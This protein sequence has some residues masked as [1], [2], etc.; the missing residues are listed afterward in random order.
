[1]L[2][3][4]LLN[5]QIHNEILWRAWDGNVYL[6]GCRM[7][8]HDAYPAEYSWIIELVAIKLDTD[9]ETAKHI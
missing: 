4:Y 1:M 2:R 6:A 8:Q 5:V 7:L 3:K 9:R